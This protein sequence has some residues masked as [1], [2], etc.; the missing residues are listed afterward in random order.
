MHLRGSKVRKVLGRKGFTLLEL[1]V[2]VCII[3]LLAAVVSPSVIK[4]LGFRLGEKARATLLALSEA[5]HNHYG[6]YGV[7]PASI[8]DLKPF[9]DSPEIED[10]WGSAIT[11]LRDVSINGI[12][13]DVVFLSKGPNTIQDSVLNGNVLE[14]GGDDIVQVVSL[15]EETP[16]DR[17]RQRIALANG[18]LA[19]YVGAYN[20]LPPGCSDYSTDCVCSLVS[21]GFLEGV[22]SYD[23]WGSLLYYLD[24][25]FYSAG[26]DREVGTGDDIG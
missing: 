4:I 23:L 5:S 14:P 11:M 3:L 12:P 25:E 6:F 24:G 18:A 16:F 26:P 7:P 13:Y 20:E 1:I 8:D 17:A 10:P 15:K 19:A 2:A 21:S 9:L 22:N